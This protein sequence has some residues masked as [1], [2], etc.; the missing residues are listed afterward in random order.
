MKKLLT[1]LILATVS[2][3]ACQT[4]QPQEPLPEQQEGTAEYANYS[5]EKVQEALAQGQTTI[6][7]FH[8]AWCPTCRAAEEEFIDNNTLP[9]NITILKLDY[10][11][12]KELKQKYGITYQH[13]FVQID[14]NLEVVKKWNGGGI[15]LIKQELNI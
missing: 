10:D 7:F 8:A 5:T 4:P 13:S 14:E 12:E 11:T 9:E 3:S 2:L 6:L 1:L 15:A